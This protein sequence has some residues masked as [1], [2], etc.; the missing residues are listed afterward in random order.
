MNSFVKRTIT[1]V[2]FVI[3]II[4]SVILSHWA[5][6]TLF[7]I[8]SLGGL[9]EFFKISKALGANLNKSLL[10]LMATLS[11]ALISL[12]AFGFFEPTVLIYGLLVFPVIMATE[13]FRKTSTPQIGRAHV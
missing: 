1:G 6:A 11:Y 10:L 5:F 7:L 9:F 8:V 13:L 12:T 2:I 4:G 3:L